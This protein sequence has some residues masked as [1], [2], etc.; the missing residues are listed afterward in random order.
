MTTNVTN[1]VKLSLETLYGTVRGT[2]SSREGQPGVFSATGMAGSLTNVSFIDSRLFSD[3]YWTPTRT[4][5]FMLG[6]KLSHAL[7]NTSLYELRATRYA[8]FYDTNPGR[9][10]DTTKVVFFGGVGFDEGPFGFQPN[11][12][13]GVDGMRMGVGMSNSRDTSRTAAY[14]FK[15]DYTNQLNRAVEFKTGAEYNLTESDI[16][17]GSYDAY[18]PSSNFNTRW[19]RNPTRLA[20]YGQTKLEYQGI[21]ANLGVRVDQSHAGGTWYD[22]DSFSSVFASYARLD[23]AQQANTKRL[24]SVSPRL[25][26]SFPITRASKLFVNYGHFRSMPSPNDLYQV[27]Y[28]AQSQQVSFI[29]NP[30]APLPKTIAYELGFEQALLRDFLLRVTGY[31]K[32]TFFEPLDVTYNGIQGGITYGQS[33]PNGYADTRGFEFTF[34][35]RRGRVLNFLLNYTYMVRTSGR[36]GTPST[37]ENPTSEKQNLDNDA[38]RRSLQSRPV[39]EPYARAVVNVLSPNRFGPS[40]LGVRPLAGWLLSAVGSWRSGTYT[41]WIDGGGSREDV[42]NNVQFVNSTNLDL[43]F[44]RDVQVGRRR[45]QVFADITNALN[46]RRLSFNG[47]IDANDRRRYFTSLHLPTAEKNE[48]TN[49]PGDDRIGAFRKAGV[50]YQPMFSIA[51]RA[52]F[53]TANP[54]AIYYER[55]TGQYLVYQ[56]GAWQ[57][58]DAARVQQVI[59]DKAYIDMPNQGFL[60]FLGPR[61]V[62]VGLRINL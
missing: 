5:D 6:A 35:K 1:R 30:N 51:D 34:E 18:L 9:L 36:F 16:N 60:T 29:A 44:A 56:S 14:N 20:V 53:T 55:A 22:Y 3:S 7:T 23:T 15:F 54:A 48:Y 17:F 24:W 28:F 50:A 31:Y 42:L 45:I 52:A 41:T 46:Q 10:R 43:R 32:N 37:F 58:V 61:D 57:P 11:P 21:I 13:N 40:V 38:T 26:V 19:D 59:D 8:S 4:R 27:R 12:S 47:F 33:E 49:I 2:A 25:G 39:P 62:Y